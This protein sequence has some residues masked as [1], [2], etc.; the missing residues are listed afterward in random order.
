MGLIHTIYTSVNV[1]VYVLSGFLPQYNA[2]ITTVKEG[3][4]KVVIGC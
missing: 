4:E 1:F 3:F 2:D